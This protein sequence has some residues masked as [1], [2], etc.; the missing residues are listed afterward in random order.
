[1]FQLFSKLFGNCLLGSKTIAHTSSV[2]KPRSNSVRP[3]RA[4]KNRRVQCRV[5]HLEERLVMDCTGVPDATVNNGVLEIVGRDNLGDLVYVTTPDNAQAVVALYDRD[6]PAHPCI[7]SR[8]F[9]LSAFNSTKIWLLGGDDEIYQSINKDSIIFGGSGNDIIYGDTAVDYLYGDAGN[10]RLYGSL[11][12]DFLFGGADNDELHGEQ[13][14]DTVYGED[15]N[16]SLYGNADDYLW[17]GHDDDTYFFA[18][19]GSVSII[20][21]PNSGT[22]TLDFSFMSVPIQ[23][24]LALTTQQNLTPGASDPLYLT[25]SSGT[26]IENVVGTNVGGSGLGDWI[27]GNSLSN[28]LDG[29]GGDDVMNGEAGTD[30]LEGGPGSDTMAGGYDNDTY[31]FGYY[32]GSLGADTIYEDPAHNDFGDTL[33]F[34]SFRKG[35]VGDNY[36]YL[37]LGSTSTQTMCDYDQS[38]CASV[39][40]SLTLSSDTAIENVIGT[41]YMDVIFGNAR[42]NWL[43]GKGA[44]DRLYGGGD[45]DHLEGGYGDD[46]LDGGADFDYYHFGSETGY[47][48]N[49]QI[50]DTSSDNELEFSQFGGS[51]TGLYLNTSGIQTVNSRL[52]LKLV[53]P[54]N[55]TDVIGSQYSDIIYGNNK[56]NYID[57]LGGDDVIWGR[58]GNDSL[59]GRSGFDRL[60]GEAGNDYLDGGQDGIADYLDGGADADTFKAELYWVGCWPNLHRV[61]RDQ[62]AQ[63]NS[64]ENDSVI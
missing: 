15:G 6:N 8:P 64:W 13:Q 1:V 52:D 11:G 53:T 47:L 29:R 7:W 35:L 37:D 61:N 12:A 31:R 43:W 17:G 22:D 44:R 51:I 34:S 54:N 62:P 23:V 30:V 41:A 55:I 19:S 27:Y 38:G 26:A 48:G 9:P 32:A 2:A 21:A 4:G 40:L 45:A 42:P 28:Y 46:D 58:G 59:Y 20:E 56:N 18:G 25:L 5:E 50:Y 60:Y 63:V 3:S 49:D 10:D 39:V 16:D 14:N 24:S 33:D 57:G 36:G